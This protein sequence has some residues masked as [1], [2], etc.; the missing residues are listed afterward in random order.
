MMSIVTVSTSS[1]LY[2]WELRW[3]SL[4]GMGVSEGV[5]G[6]KPDLQR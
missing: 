5:V 1:F 3:T 6:L 2:G 4:A